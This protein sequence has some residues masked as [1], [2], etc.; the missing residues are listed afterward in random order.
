[1]KEKQKQITGF[2]SREYRKLVNYVKRRLTNIGEM[3]GEDIV[4]DVALNIFDKVD[5]SSPIENLASYVYASLRNKV[6]DM[7]IKRKK[8]SNVSNYIEDEAPLVE[9]LPDNKQDVHLIV[10]KKELRQKIFEA[11]N[12]LSDDQKAI[13]V[14]TEVEGYKFQELADKW[15]EPIGT[16]LARKHRATKNLQEKLKNITA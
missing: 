2:F 15:G 7:Y 5:F 3:D 9:I 10:E 16:L 6:V 12:T 13:W 11:V 8:L 1:M 14:A 4:Q